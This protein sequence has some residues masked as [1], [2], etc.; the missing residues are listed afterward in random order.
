MS[1]IWGFFIDW[2]EIL[3]IILCTLGLNWV[4]NDD[5]NNKADDDDYIKKAR[6]H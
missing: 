2:I 5:D 3:T 1:E 4:N 6:R